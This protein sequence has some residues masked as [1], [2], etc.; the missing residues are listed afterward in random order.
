M[1]KQTKVNPQN[2]PRIQDGVYAGCVDD[3]TLRQHTQKISVD[4]FKRMIVAA[5]EDANAKSGRG[6]VILPADADEKTVN[7]IYQN[8]AKKL[9]TY[10][11]QYPSD[12]ASEAYILF[13]KHYREVGIDAFKS[14]VVQKGRM[15]SGWRYQYLS[16]DAAR[17][18][19]RFRSV[20]DTG[21]S[22]GDFTAVIDF[23]DASRKPLSLYVSVKNR[24]NT[25]GGQDW[26]KAIHALEKIANE[27]KNRVGPY[28]CVFG[29]AMDRGERYIKRQQKTVH[30]HSPNTE[31]WLSDFFWP[32]FTNYSYEEIMTLV[33]EVLIEQS[34]TNSVV[35]QE[36]AELPSQVEVPEAILTYFGQHCAKAGLVNEDGYFDDP[37]KLV[38]FFCTKPRTKGG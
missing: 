19:G 1:V 3:A 32:F 30:A 2:Y 28:C 14:R 20:S 36:A 8:E 27:D 26:P 10:F 21:T 38:H 31:V 17:A 13:R 16:V 33:L 29:I 12:P 6:G 7:K 34:E 5:I 18:S 37:R 25:L 35:A 9:F 23:Q 15:N 4:A 24:K 11:R 22:E